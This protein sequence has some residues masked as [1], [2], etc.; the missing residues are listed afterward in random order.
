ME[1]VYKNVPKDQWPKA[2]ASNSPGKESGLLFAAVG[3][4]FAAFVLVRAYGK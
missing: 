4:F 3:F 2:T 1:E